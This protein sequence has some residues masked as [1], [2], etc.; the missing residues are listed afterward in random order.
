[1]AIILNIET[2]TK[3]CSVSLANDGITIACKELAT[4]HFS[5]A[6]KLHVFITEL[7]DENNIQYAHLEA[8]AISQGPGS[9][10]GDI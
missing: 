8:V 10:T 1:M 4:A 9:Y 2:A 5:H 6:E 7:L 3:N